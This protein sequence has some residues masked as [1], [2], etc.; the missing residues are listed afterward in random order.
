MSIKGLT[1]DVR[2]PRL[3][4]IKL[5]YRD[6]ERGFPVKTDYF[7]LPEDHSDNKRLV[8][9]FGA[10]PKEL[11][12]LIPVEDE[13]QWATQYYKSYNLTRG[14]V[15]KGDGETATRMVDI[16]TNNLPTKE[17]VTVEFKDV[18]CAGRDCPEYKAGKCGEVMNLKFLLPEVPGIG[19]WQI[20]TGSINSILNINSC[21]R[22]IKK[23]FGRIS[24]IPLTLSLEP[25]EVNN[26]KDGKRQ[27][28]YVLNLRTNV[29][30]AQ[31]A[32]NAREQVK[33]LALEAP[34]YAAIM[35][36]RTERDI[37]EL[38]PGDNNHKEQLPAAT[39]KIT[40]TPELVTPVINEQNHLKRDPKTIKNFGQLYTACK[41]D[42]PE[43]FN[44]PE[45]HGDCRKAVWAELGYQ[46]QE[47]IT[48][49]PSLCYIKIAELRLQPVP[50]K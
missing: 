16:K 42:W 13:E 1:E 17:T 35:E 47:D 7:V 9:L 33:A 46:S 2:I 21:A 8:E 49:D 28:V 44:K 34:D 11:R 29:T 4:K 30:L 26:P 5:G 41:E 22:V 3:G 40:K 19:V 24:L 10:K 39:I 20:D 32:D 50:K 14:L 38:W 6:K 15:C 43:A 27:T 48:E 36:E 31:L 25:I 18:T 23:A 45:F 37:E 12:I